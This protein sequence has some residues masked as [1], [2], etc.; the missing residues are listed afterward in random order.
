MEAVVGCSA[1]QDILQ[2]AI[3]CSSSEPLVK[4][5][6]K[7]TVKM[8]FSRLAS[9]KTATLLKSGFLHKYFLRIKISNAE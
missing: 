4:I 3:K 7:I 5:F 6:K 1:K 8:F 2:K 9:V